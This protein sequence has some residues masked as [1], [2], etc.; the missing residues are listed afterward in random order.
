MAL[1][2]KPSTRWRLTLGAGS[3]ER[4]DTYVG[5]YDYGSWVGY[6]SLDHRPGPRARLQLYTSVRRLDYDIPAASFV[7]GA[8]IPVDGGMSIRHT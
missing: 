3:R 7:H 6:A 1:R 2:L 4:S 5:Y 8:S